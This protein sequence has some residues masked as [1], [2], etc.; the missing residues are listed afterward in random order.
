MVFR[1]HPEISAYEEG[2]QEAVQAHAWI[3]ENKWGIEKV[4]EV[5]QGALDLLENNERVANDPE[6]QEILRGFLSKL[7]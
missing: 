2:E 6:W 3:A 5:G 4:Q 1:K 7:D